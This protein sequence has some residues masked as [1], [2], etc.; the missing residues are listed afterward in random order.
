VDVLVVYTAAVK[1]SCGGAD[2]VKAKINNYVAET[3][4]AFENSG[5]QAKLVLV[6]TDEVNYSESNAAF[7]SYSDD[8]SSLRAGGIPAKNSAKTVSDLREDYKADLVVLIREGTGTN[9]NGQKNI[10]GIAYLLNSLYSGYGGERSYVAVVGRDLAPYTFAHEIG[11][12][13]GCGHESENAQNSGL[14]PYSHGYVYTTRWTGG[15]LNMFSYS[16]TYGTIMSYSGI[17]RPRF[18]NPR[19]STNEGDGG[20]WDTANSVPTG[21]AAYADNARTINETVETVAAYRVSNRKVANP[22]FFFSGDPDANNVYWDSVDV[23]ISTPTP[24]AVIYYTTDGT[25]PTTSSS[26]YTGAIRIY[27]G[28]TTTILARAFRETDAYLPSD[29]VPQTIKIAETAAD[30]V[31]IGYSGKLVS[32]LDNERI[33]DGPA[34]IWLSAPEGSVIRYTL[35]GTAVTETSPVFSGENSICLSPDASPVT[36]RARAFREGYRPGEEVVRNYTINKLFSTPPVLS[37]N[38]GTFANSVTFSMWTE[39]VGAHFRYSTDGVNWD[40]FPVGGIVLTESTS[41]SAFSW[42]LNY[43]DS[44]I[45]N[46]HFT[47]LP[48]SELLARHANTAAAGTNHSLFVNANNTL[49]AGGGNESGQIIGDDTVP[50]KSLAQIASDVANVAAGNGFSLW[51]TSDLTL[52]GTGLNTYGQISGDAEKITSP[53]RIA[54]NVLLFAAGGGHSLFTTTDNKL[55]ALGRNNHGQLGTTDAQEARAPVFVASNILLVAAGASHSLFVSCD[56]TLYGTGHN[57]FGQLGTGDNSDYSTPVKIA[58]KVV[59]V[60]AGD[61]HSVFLKD[62][63]TV[64]AMGYNAYGQL[65]DGT[66]QYRYSPVQVAENAVAVAAGTFHTLILKNDGTVWGVGRN[67]AG[68][69]GNPAVGGQSLSFVQAQLPQN[70]EAVSIAAGGSHSIAELKAFLSER[71]FVAFGNNDSGQLGVG[72]TTNRETPTELAYPPEITSQPESTTVVEGESATFSVASR[73]AQDEPLFY[74]WFHDGEPLSGQTRETLTL[75]NVSPADAGLYKVRVT[76]SGGAVFSDS[77]T[78]S[79]TEIMQ[80]TVLPDDTGGGTVT[81]SGAFVVGTTCPISAT[82]NEGWTFVAWNDGDTSPTRSI[83]ATNEDETY[84]AHFERESNAFEI[85]RETF[86]KIRAGQLR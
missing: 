6:G 31:A 52:Y 43:Y 69:L 84:T 72:D 70:E 3:N 36:L 2:G 34:W 67:D 41:F 19:I 42:S 29:I 23:V 21:N 83:V 8:L 49:F 63:G 16:E 58:E 81:G 27:Q 22:S 5:V 82:P 4:L 79:V 15:F 32:S 24:N 86:D 48:N 57:S 38:G 47:I 7:D 77:V 59:A 1:T 74:Q 39:A 33:Y 10:A 85:F 80:L 60:A 75:T 12:T 51:T 30:T 25:T 65:G 73:S 20:F 50:V 46:A 62:D 64:W 53:A 40:D 35:D 26:K 76:D 14:F 61:Y 37:V 13:F 68:Q 9:A 66:T 11:H 28:G 54:D 71:I 45:V 44:T 17:T 78:L 55:Y 56:G 18:S